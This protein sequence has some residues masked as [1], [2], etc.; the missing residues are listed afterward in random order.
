MINIL[1]KFEINV[2]EG[3][4]LLKKSKINVFEGFVLLRK[5]EIN[6]FEG[7][8]LLRKALVICENNFKDSK[9]LLS[10]VFS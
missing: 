10:I 4:V 1:R 5:S 3:F 6:V 7:F 9:N 8:V 2:F